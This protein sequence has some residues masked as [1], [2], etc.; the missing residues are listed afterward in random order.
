VNGLHPAGGNGKAVI[1]PP[2]ANDESREQSPVVEQ[3][4]SYITVVYVQIVACL[5]D[6]YDLDHRFLYSFFAT[7]L[8]GRGSSAGQC[9]VRLKRTVSLARCR[10]IGR[11]F[12]LNRYHP[13]F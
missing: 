1:R 2:P 13:S 7:E 12:P 9:F 6:S 8:V 11:L 10:R 4:S 3:S 5:S